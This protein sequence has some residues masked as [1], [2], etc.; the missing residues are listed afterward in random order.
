MFWRKLRAKFLLFSL[1]WCS[2]GGLCFCPHI[3]LSAANVVGLRN[4]G[5]S[6]Y[7]N[8]AIQQMY[9]SKSFRKIICDLYDTEF[10]G[11][12]ETDIPEEKVFL[13]RF[14]SFFYTISQAN[15]G[16]VIGSELMKKTIGNKID[17]RGDC[18]DRA[19]SSIFSSLN[20]S[21]CD[22]SSSF[23]ILSA[24]NIYSALFPDIDDLSSEE[25]SLHM[26][27]VHKIRPAPNTIN[28]DELFQFMFTNGFKDHIKTTR[29][30]NN[31]LIN[32][33]FFKTKMDFIIHENYC[34]EEGN[35]TLQSLAINTGGHFITWVKDDV[36]AWTRI[37]DSCISNKNCEFEKVLQEIKVKG[38]LASAMYCKV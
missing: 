21:G 14:A 26:E 2:T 10:K 36:G 9:S 5:N 30:I 37:S 24:M 34:V 17:R 28:V 33:D 27:T 13:Y 35:F 22:F 15:D 23:K 3:K 1:V 29:S 25:F 7:Y 8:S 4:I 38:N 11:K 32:L 31:V 20:E 6:C 18:I 19:F 16:E 12:Q